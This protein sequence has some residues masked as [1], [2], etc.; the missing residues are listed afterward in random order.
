MATEGIVS[1]LSGP[2]MGTRNIEKGAFGRPFLV[3]TTFSA[4]A[5]RSTG[6]KFN[7]TPPPSMFDPVSSGE[8]T[9]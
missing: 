7:R 4:A 2:D 8:I 9:P 1:N 3:P 6:Q 5:V